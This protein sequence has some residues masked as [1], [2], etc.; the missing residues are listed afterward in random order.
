MVGVKAHEVKLNPNGRWLYVPCLGDNWVRMF[1]FNSST[2]QL[3]PL[4]YPSNGPRA[5]LGNRA[6]VPTGSGPRHLAFHPTLPVAYL[7]NEL[8]STVARFDWERSASGLLKANFTAEPQRI[9]SML[10]PQQQLQNSSEPGTSNTTRQ[11]CFWQAGAELAISF[12]GRYL[13][14]S[15]RGSCGG[16]SSI[17]MF[18]INQ[19][20]GSLQAKGWWQVEAVPRHMSLTPDKQNAYL[21]VANQYK[22]S[23]TVFKRDSVTGM[24]TKGMTVST[25]S[26]AGNTTLP[27]FIAAL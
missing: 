26:P 8:A 12:D 22:N 2:G 3:T 6:P 5:S 27:S 16:V 21:L 23:V 13:Y 15:N 7:L 11:A 18:A 19:S 20:S 9:T 4:N 24:L 14:A 10:P 17:V 1:S 25:L